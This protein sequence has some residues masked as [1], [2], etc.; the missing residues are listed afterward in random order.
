M[1]DMHLT[2]TF[3]FD[4]WY[5]EVGRS[6]LDTFWMECISCILKGIDSELKRMINH[7]LIKTLGDFDLDLN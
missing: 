5:R 1:Q 7:G 6:N 2:L 3:T 4:I